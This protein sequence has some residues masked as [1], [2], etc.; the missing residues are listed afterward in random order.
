M[1]GTRNLKVVQNL[2]TIIR[3][4]IASLVPVVVMAVHPGL[5]STLRLGRGYKLGGRNHRG[6]VAKAPIS[7][8]WSL[9]I[10]RS[11][12]KRATGGRKRGAPIDD[13]AKLY[14]C[15]QTFWV[16]DSTLAAH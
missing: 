4:Q 11:S 13:S 6:H 7:S 1:G 12:R 2:Y 3:V 16:H 14:N 5:K 15:A 9:Y 10:N 8:L